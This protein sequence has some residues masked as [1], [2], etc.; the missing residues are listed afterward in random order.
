MTTR[1]PR[2]SEV[3]G[4]DYWFVTRQEFERRIAAGELL[5]WAE[6][7]QDLYGTPRAPVIE[8]LAA[9][10]HVVLDIENEGARQVRRSYPEAVLVFVL[11][12]SLAVLEQR[13]RNRGD[14]ADADA[15]LAVA[16]EQIAAAPDL[17]DYVVVNDDLDA[18]IS[19]VADILASPA[20]RPQSVTEETP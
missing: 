16:R 2:E 11:P 20:A 9:G 4:V 1:P 18:A 15:R 3:D 13:L 7:N 12:P 19:R 8:Q 6:Y 17:F 14:T 10:H 5:E